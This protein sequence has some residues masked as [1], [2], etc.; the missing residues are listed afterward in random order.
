MSKLVS[1]F[2]DYNSDQLVG[3]IVSLLRLVTMVNFDLLYLRYDVAGSCNQQ[4]LHTGIASMLSLPFRSVMDQS[5]RP[6]SYY[7]MF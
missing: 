2:L 7:V 3:V 6:T 4:T 1:Y 5:A